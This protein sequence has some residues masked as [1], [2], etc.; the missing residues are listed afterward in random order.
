MQAQ[1][2]NIN[3]KSK[4]TNW[5]FSQCEPYLLSEL[6]NALGEAKIIKD[7]LVVSGLDVLQVRLETPFSLEGPGDQSGLAH[8]HETGDAG[9]PGALP[10]GLQPGHQLGDWPA[11]LPWCQVA[12]LLGNVVEDVS[13]FLVTLLNTVA[14]CCQYPFSRVNIFQV[15]GWR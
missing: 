14:P 12:R 5:I 4:K 8:G 10:A 15:E 1:N 3:Y 2:H 13:S 11:D 6:D 9:H 7:E